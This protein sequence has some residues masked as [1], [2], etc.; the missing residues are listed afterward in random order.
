MDNIVSGAG[1]REVVGICISLSDE[2]HDHS[3]RKWRSKNF[4]Q[5]LS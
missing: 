5:D 2:L 1:G 3:N 4:D